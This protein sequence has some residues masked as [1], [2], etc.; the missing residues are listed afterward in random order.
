MMALTSQ[1][2]TFIYE[3]GT[4]CS[5]LPMCGEG[6]LLPKC[7]LGTPDGKKGAPNCPNEA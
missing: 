3:L 7:P 2:V 1:I 5:I 4:T 6:M